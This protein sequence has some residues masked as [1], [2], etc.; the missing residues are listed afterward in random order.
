M[1]REYCCEA[2][3]ANYGAAALY[4]HFGFMPFAGSPRILYLPLATAARLLPP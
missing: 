2:P 4:R 3:A 1:S